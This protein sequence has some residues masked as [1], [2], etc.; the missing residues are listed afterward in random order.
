[1]TTGEVFG[2]DAKLLQ[3]TEPWTAANAEFAIPKLEKTQ[4]KEIDTVA[5]NF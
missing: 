3:V 2:P 4:N 1:M 5:Q